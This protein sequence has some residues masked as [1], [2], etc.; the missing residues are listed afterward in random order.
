MTTEGTKPRKSA[1]EFLASDVFL[2][3]LVAVL[4]V[5]TAF[6]AFQ[7]SMADSKESDKNVEAQQVLSLSNTEFLRANQ[8]IIQDYTMYD[9]WWINDG[10]NAEN[11]EYYMANFSEYLTASMD[12]EGGPF[13][14]QY[15]DEMYTDADSSFDEAMGLY[16]EAQAAGD[17][18]DRYQLILM[19]FAVGLS[20]GAWASL[21]DGE[22]RI[23]KFFSLF[24]VVLFIFGLVMTIGIL[25]V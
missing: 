13:D 1:F 25:I 20:M 6:A 3:T 17:K 21:L 14:D 12:R 24:S 11:A 2:G 23:R 16:D 8:D 5:F 19:I 22:N 4:S 15:Y 10:V 9:G 7:G 18:A